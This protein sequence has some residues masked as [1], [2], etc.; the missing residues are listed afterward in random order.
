MIRYRRNQNP[1]VLPSS[2]VICWV[3]LLS[4][5][6]IA[7]ANPLDRIVAVV[8]TDVILLSEVDEQCKY[9]LKQVPSSLS[10]EESTKRKTQ[11]RKD[12]LEI[13]IDELLIKQ[14]IK[15]HHISVTDEE[16]DRYID[17]VKKQNKLSDEQFEMALSQ[18]GMTLADFRD[19]QR[20]M[21]KKRKLLGREIQ[22]KLRVTEK[23]IYQ[24]YQKHYLSGGQSER[25][26]ASHILFAFPPD[27]PEDKLALIKQRAKQ[28][29]ASLQE[30]KDFAEIAMK[31]SDDPSASVGGNLGWFRKG[32][33][34]SAFEDVAFSLEKGAMSGLVRTRFGYHI[35]K[36]VDRQK[37]E[38][39]A[40]EKV[41]AKI[42]SVLEKEL[43]QRLIRTWL[44]GLRRRSHID[45]K[46]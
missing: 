38:P 33:M 37:D 34:V 43:E 36:V 8:N 46:L 4:G 15:E 41:S 12:A 27:A 21:F 1:F 40:L 2:L 9:S 44:D 3:C 18:E 29:L 5:Y 42:R 23:E 39:Q 11:I 17:M 22:S 16:V 26:K 20:S 25:I 14:Q 10:E 13:L 35:I 19:K 30:G 24:Y 7:L 28:V 31:E 6:P 45:I 32:D